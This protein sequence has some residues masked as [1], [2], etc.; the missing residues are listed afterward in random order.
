[1]IVDAMKRLF[2][3]LLEKQ[4]PR[5]HPRGAQK[6]CALG[7][8]AALGMTAFFLIAC[9]LPVSAHIGSP[10]VFL[11][12][13]AGPYKLF[14]TVRVPQVIPGIAE[15]EIRSESNGVN[16]IRIA[17]MQLTGPG[18]Q[19]APAPE[20][21]QRSK[22]DPQF[23][24]GSLWLMEF[25]SL[26]VRIEADGASGKG[27][28][29]V[30]IPAV[31]Q[32]M[33]PMQRSLGL[34]LFG[35]MLV[36][37]LAMVSIVAAAVREGNLA[38]G[39]PMPAAR[40]RRVQIAAAL[41]GFVVAAV[42]ALGGLWWRADA[43]QYASHIYNA[44]AI[45]AAI[46]SNGQLILRAGPLHMASGNPRRPADVID[47]KDL[48]VDHEHLMHLFLVRSPGMDVFWHLHPERAGS[49]SFIQNLPAMPAGQY[50]IFADV[51]LSNGFPVTM[52]G[53]IDLPSAIAGKALTGDD[54]GIA[55]NSILSETNAPAEFS[56]PD[57]G[58]MDWKRD[59][60]PVQPLQAGVPLI[61][62][63]RVTDPS[64]RPA[65][66]LE[67]YMG[68][69]AHAAIVRSDGSVF[70]HV[71]PTG[72]VPMASFELA[73]ASLPGASSGAALAPMNMPQMTGDKVAPDISIPYGFPKAGL[74][75]VFV[76]IKRAGQIETA[77]FDAAVR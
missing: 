35:L 63:F 8:P 27:L 12:G 43:R 42:L 54:S 73:Q 69:P 75:R 14:V 51:V 66:D 50:H 3:I 4:I 62:H 46:N 25:G 15:I 1:V 31:A 49:G 19:Y 61:L 45:E 70:A 52:I 76:Q 6:R 17:P 7:T 11:E 21:A 20:A 53:Q 58:H 57:G 67:P 13:N 24:R 29:A 32:R 40:K 48:I 44:P 9:A 64:G 18:S 56:F 28:L 74:Y 72:S 10:D 71:H 16:E 59:A 22:D 33:L 60:Q 30:P 36:L 65:P 38:P 41:A 34:L 68:M 77:F 39:A 23:F 47:F 2:A 5:L 26:Q 55:G 37:A